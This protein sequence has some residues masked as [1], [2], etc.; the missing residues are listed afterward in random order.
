[1]SARKSKGAEI[2]GERKR[3]KSDVSPCDIKTAQLFHDNYREHKISTKGNNFAC[4]SGWDSESGKAAI[5]EWLRV[6]AREQVRMYGRVTRNSEAALYPLII[7]A[8]LPV[9]DLWDCTSTASIAKTME[10]DDIEHVAGKIA[11]TQSRRGSRQTSAEHAGPSSAALTP[12]LCEDVISLPEFID[13][14]DETQ[15]KQ[16]MVY[17]EKWINSTEYATKGWVEILISE[18]SSEKVVA[19]IE[20][21]PH[22]SNC[23]PDNA[24]LYQCCAYMALK[25]VPYGIFTDHKAFQFVRMDDNKV[26]HR[27]ELIDLMKTSYK[28][29]DEEAP[30]VNAYLF[31]IM[32][33]PRNTDLLA[34]AAESAATWAQRAAELTARV[35]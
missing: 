24:G 25:N 33:V 11:E 18:A 30:E 10:L 2:S 6:V 35:V 32:G 9:F 12:A 31:E 3:A 26:L 34:K 20:A 22:I 13:T 17:I 8:L 16:F 21:K 5:A 15:V 29:L 4:T 23:E 27:S 7:A 19:V 1:M 28:K 14:T